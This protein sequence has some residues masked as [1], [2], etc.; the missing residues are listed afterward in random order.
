MSEKYEK[1]KKEKILEKRK[2]EVKWGKNL[3]RNILAKQF[4]TK[5]KDV[6]VK[7]WLEK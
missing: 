6:G 3:I 4:K 2:G 7:I 5:V 1:L